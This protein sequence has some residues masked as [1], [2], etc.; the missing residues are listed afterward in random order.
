MNDDQVRL[1]ASGISTGETRN[2]MSCPECSG[3]TNDKAFSIT[4][5]AANEIK[6]ICFRATCGYKGHISTSNVHAMCKNNAKPV[7]LPKPLE[8][9]DLSKRTRTQLIMRYPNL[10]MEFIDSCKEEKYRILIPIRDRWGRIV[11]HNRRG[12]KW[13]KDFYGPKSITDWQEDPYIKSDFSWIN[14]SDVVYIVEDQL[15]AACI[16]NIT[17]A[18][19]LA[20]L[21][22][23]VSNNLIAI[24]K[25]Q[26]GCTEIKVA[27]DQDAWAKAAKIE[28]KF[29]LL[30]VSS[31]QWES[32][33]DPKDMPADELKEVF[34]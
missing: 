1:L 20:L 23:H 15:S 2:G 14:K 3:V 25:Q 30:G 19:C 28:K 9:Y 27:L 26:Y 13:F 33:L 29:R 16:S 11:G 17:G 5:T 18:S 12:Y 6:F 22:S 10:P 4:R 21:G 31:M 24:L 7:D 8:Y 32:G 34:K